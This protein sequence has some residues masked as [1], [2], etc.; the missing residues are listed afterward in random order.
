M[1]QGGNAGSGVD[2]KI[3]GV[4]T[5]A[6]NEPYCLVDGFPMDLNNVNP[7]DIETMEILK[8]GAAAAIYGSRAANGV[9]LITT[10]NGTKGDVSVDINALQE[11]HRLPTGWIC[12]MQKG[13]KKCIR[14]CIRMQA[15]RCLLMSQHP[16]KQT[17][18]GSI[19]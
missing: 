15:R 16:D 7:S 11:S 8:D 14:K 5:F 6:D 12:W 19:Q 13:I 10:K 17:P 18:T 1:R 9:I 4:S 2:I 3:R